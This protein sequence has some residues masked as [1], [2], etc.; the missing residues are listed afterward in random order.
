MGVANWSDGGL[1]CWLDGPRRCSSLF[2]TGLVKT[3]TRTCSVLYAGEF[4]DILTFDCAF[5]SE[6]TPGKRQIR[7]SGNNRVHRKG[8]LLG[9]AEVLRIAST[10]KAL[11]GQTRPRSTHGEPRPI[12]PSANPPSPMLPYRPTP[13]SHREALL[14]VDRATS[15]Q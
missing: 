15:Q 10:E 2:P 3:S 13:E 11:V 4:H 14:A 5:G 1:D 7:Q 8:A 6:R 9:F 12:S